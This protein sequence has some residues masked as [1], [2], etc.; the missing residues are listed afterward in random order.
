M[1]KNGMGLSF[2]YKD[3][4][5]EDIRSG[6]L[7]E[8]GVWDF[9]IEREFNFIHLKNHIDQDEID[10]FFSFFKDNLV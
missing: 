7:A 2:M 6:Q 3:A 5:K 10:K 1:V 4:A 8:V 9:E